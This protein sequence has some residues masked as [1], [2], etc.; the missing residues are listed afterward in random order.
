MC[1]VFGGIVYPVCFER[2]LRC[3]LCIVRALHTHTTWSVSREFGED[4]II[5]RHKSIL[6]YI[7]D[8]QFF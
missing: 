6:Y 4:M 5:I 7:A 2:V 8:C 1:P 3:V